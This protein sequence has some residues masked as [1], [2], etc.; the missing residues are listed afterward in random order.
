M[1]IYWN[2]RL[3]MSRDMQTKPKSLLNDDPFEEAGFGGLFSLIGVN[4][5]ILAGMSASVRM[6][7]EMQAP[8]FAPIYP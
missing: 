6:S 1:G 4:T 7:N 2:E 5:M 3:A 8:D